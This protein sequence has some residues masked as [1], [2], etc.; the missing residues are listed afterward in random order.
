MGIIF[1]SH[2]TDED[3][4]VDMVDHYDNLK[5]SLHWINE[6]LDKCEQNPEVTMGDIQKMKKA[7]LKIFSKKAGFIKECFLSFPNFEPNEIL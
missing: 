2:G 3:L 7:V 6:L 5:V 1:S 4:Y